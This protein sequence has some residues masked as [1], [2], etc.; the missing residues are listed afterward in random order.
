MF[1][2][3]KAS[4]NDYKLIARIG[5]IAVEE[6][7]QKSCSAESLSEFLHKNY[8]EESIQK[9][10]L[11]TKNLYHLIFCNEEP[12]GFSK[13][14]LNEQHLNII[15]KNVTKLDRIYL[16]KEF[17]NLKLG[18]ELLKFNM[19]LSKKNNQFG[20]YLFTWIG[21]ERAINFYLKIG[22][23]IIGSHQLKITET[24]SNPNHH[25]YLKY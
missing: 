5:K 18:F 4:E 25:M 20:I 11:E 23:K 14:I 3:I 7:H 2:I 12:A 13:I 15:D 9:D 16:L 17:H 22:F 10:L 19:E 8:N 24:H 6:A 1:S 21:N